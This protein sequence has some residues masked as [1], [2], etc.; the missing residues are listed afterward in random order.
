V[1]GALDAGRD[2]RDV[3]KFRPHANLETVL[4]YDDNRADVAGSVADLAAGDG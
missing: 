2:V 4:V 3:R 1:T